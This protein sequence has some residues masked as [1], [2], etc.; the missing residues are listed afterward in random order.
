MKKPLIIISLLVFCIIHIQ[1]QRWGVA[2]FG[3]GVNNN[4]I[5]NTSR[6]L[7]TGDSIYVNMADSKYSTF[8]YFGQGD[9]F[10][11]HLYFSYDFG[12][13]FKKSP[14]SYSGVAASTIAE[15][16]R[17]FL[18]FDLGWGNWSGHGLGW[19]LGLKY[20]AEAISSSVTS[21]GYFDLEN[22]SHPELGNGTIITQTYFGWRGIGLFAKGMSSFMDNHLMVHGS[23]SLFPLNSNGSRKREYGGF[24]KMVFSPEISVN[25]LFG[26]G[27]NWG[28][29]LSFCSYRRFFNEELPEEHDPEEQYSTPDQLWKVNNLE[30]KLFIGLGN[31]KKYSVTVN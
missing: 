20:E 3:V 22:Y 13:S 17:R 11:E 26:D 1:G 6:F 7:A 28:A 12:L 23:V 14:I 24:G 25:Y 18:K 8:Y 27:R 21:F 16:F 30:L 4:Q 9:L 31:A 15:V 10:K 2:G 5:T 19:W 29:G